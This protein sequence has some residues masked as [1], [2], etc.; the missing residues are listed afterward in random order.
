MESFHFRLILSW[1]MYKQRCA[2]GSLQLSQKKWKELL[3][4]ELHKWCGVPKQ[5]D[6]ALYGYTFSGKFLYEDQ[7][8]FLT[9][10]GFRPTEF[11]ALW[12]KTYDDG[13]VMFVLQ[14]SDDFIAAGTLTKHEEDFKRAISKRFNV[15]ITPA[16][17]GISKREFD[18]MHMETSYSINKDILSRLSDVICQTPQL[19]RHPTMSTNTVHLFLLTSNG[20]KRT[21]RRQE[22]MSL[23]LRLNSDSDISK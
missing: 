7:A 15:I 17:T 5:M 13:A 18:K 16:Q 22:R 19:I 6:K 9:E 23:L 12:K 10:Q 11:I 3:P 4:E 8:D 1:H 2:S 20:P 21:I 14:Y